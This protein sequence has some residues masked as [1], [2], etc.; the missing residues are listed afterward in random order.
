MTKPAM[1]AP[2]ARRVSSSSPLSLNGGAP[3]RFDPELRSPALK[4]GLLLKCG[5]NIKNWKQRLCVLTERGELEYYAPEESPATKVV[6]TDKQ[7][8]GRINCRNATIRT[9][10][11]VR[12]SFNRSSSTAAGSSATASEGN[13]KETRE[14]AAIADMVTTD[15]SHLVLKNIFTI[16][17]ASQ[18]RLFELQAETLEER[19]AWVAALSKFGDG[20]MIA[21]PSKPN[22]KARE[23]LFGDG[24]GNAAASAG[25]NSN[26]ERDSEAD[27][28]VLSTSPSAASPRP[29]SASTHNVHWH[30]PAT[31]HKHLRTLGVTEQSYQ[32]FQ[33]AEKAY[34]AL[35][36]YATTGPAAG[37]NHSS[38]PSSPVLS[39]ASPP[40]ASSS[41]SSTSSASASGQPTPVATLL[42]TLSLIHPPL[43]PPSNGSTSPAP[44]N[45]NN[46]SNK[47][48]SSNSSSSNT[49]P[50][51]GTLASVPGANI[52]YAG[53]LTK[54]GGSGA[55][56]SWKKRFFVLTH[57]GLIHY[58]LSADNIHSKTH[59][60]G[61][62]DAR[63]AMIRYIDQQEYQVNHCFSVVPV[64]LH[65]KSYVLAAENF[66]ELELWVS[67]LSYFGDGPSNAAALG[68]QAGGGG[69]GGGGA[70][71]NKAK[72]VL[73]GG[74]KEQ[75]ALLDK[76]GT[77][78]Q[79][80]EKF[81]ANPKAYSKL[82][83]FDQN[84]N[85]QNL[86]AS[87]S[88][89]NSANTSST[90]S[91][92]KNSSS[93]SSTAAAS[94]SS[95][96]STSSAISSSFPSI[97][98]YNIYG[99]LLPDTS[100]LRR[101][102]LAKSGGTFKSSKVRFTVLTRELLVY[103][104]SEKEEKPK[105][106]I[107][108][109]RGAV[110]A[111]ANQQGGQ[112]GFTFSFTITPGSGSSSNNSSNAQ[113]NANSSSGLSEREYVFWATDEQTRAAWVELLQAVASKQPLDHLLMRS[114]SPSSAFTSIAGSSASPSPIPASVAASVSPLLLQSLPST[115]SFIYHPLSLTNPFHVAALTGF[116]L[117]ACALSFG[118]NNQF[119]FS[120]LYAGQDGRGFIDRCIRRLKTHPASILLIT[121]KKNSNDSSSSSS[122]R[123]D[124]DANEERYVGAL[125]LELSPARSPDVTI[126]SPNY[127][128]P[129]LGSLAY[130]SLFYLAPKLRHK[131]LGRELDEFVLKF[132]RGLKSAT[133]PASTGSTMPN[134][135]LHN[136]QS[137]SFQRIR[138]S[139]S[140]S[141]E[142]AIKFYNKMGYKEVGETVHGNEANTKAIIMEKE[143]I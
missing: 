31:G 27:A 58:F 56:A 119:F 13:S 44:N 97:P 77:N 73:F 50:S 88:N 112:P 54:L 63:H 49:A 60:K 23:I 1:S 107:D 103:Y 141:N 20:P 68:H 16:L 132:L 94:S 22:D 135:L 106:Q 78:Q 66:T 36:A 30:M 126:T 12:P 55:F 143:L 46:D 62:I 38:A 129:P 26:E 6:R 43:L 19:D 2:S 104:A 29:G 71:S 28:T 91:P 99:N 133:I 142:P 125:E 124:G 57:A 139:V 53:Y 39:S 48:S 108:L 110:V 41:S 114:A 100:I 35:G 72:D 79:T 32:K 42:T 11:P 131:G 45:T 86:V 59:L 33:G 87:S 101:G 134:P 109:T 7:F 74:K 37:T 10:D 70:I 80:L 8:K 118:G 5:G 140:P 67:A 137:Y 4:V 128:H 76:L 82:G 89:Y 117:D 75:S 3:L 83:M 116:R 98:R 61:T 111:L 24:K 40:A 34:Q 127:T 138:L 14:V 121:E 95:S 85:L 17:P 90:A 65:S 69:G 52:Y 9:R 96:S 51:L 84:A 123:A 47:A 64:T 136:G 15:P 92:P 113:S 18:E 130:V 25:V 81:K 93:S 115:S 120:D 122:S 21:P 105:G 102:F